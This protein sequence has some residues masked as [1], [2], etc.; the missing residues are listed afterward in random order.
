MSFHEILSGPLGQRLAWTLLHFLWQ[1]LLIGAGTAA[2]GWLLS[3]SHT[4]GRY[5]IAMI[6]LVLMACCPLVTFAILQVPA[7]PL[8]TVVSQSDLPVGKPQPPAPMQAPDDDMALPTP[9]P[10]ASR[11]VADSQPTPTPVAPP[12]EIDWRESLAR[13]ASAFQPYAVMAWLAGVVALGGRLMMSVLAV[14]RLARG[15]MPVAAE[16]AACA[17]R[18]AQRLGLS[19]SP[20]IYLSRRILEAMLVGLWRPMVLLPAAWIAEMPP[21]VL[22]AV[23]AHELAHMRRLD[24]WANLMQRLVETLLFYHPAVWW[25]SRRASLLRE[26]CADDLAVQATGDRMS[27]AGVLELLGRRRLNPPAPQLAAGIGGR[28]M[29]LFARVRNVLGAA[30]GDERLRW[31]PAG[32]L[33]LLVPLGMWLVSMGIAQTQPARLSAIVTKSTAGAEPAVPSDKATNPSGKT[34]AAN[35]ANTKPAEALTYKGT[36]VDTDGKPVKGAKIYLLYYTAAE[37]PRPPVRA[38]SGPDGTFQ[39]KMAKSEFVAR[40][41]AHDPWLLSSVVAIADGQGIGWQAGEYLEAEKQAGKRASSGTAG[42]ASSSGDKQSPDETKP[43]IRLVRDDVPIVGRIVDAKRRP[44]AGASVRILE[45]IGNR[46]NSLT[47]WLD[48]VEKRKEGYYNA[49]KYLNNGL[50]GWLRNQLQHLLPAA[51]TDQDGRFR[52]TGVG[53]ERIAHL[54][55]EGPGIA[56]EQLDVRTRPGPTLHVKNYAGEAAPPA[57]TYY[58]AE[59]EHIAAPSQQIAGTVRDKNTHLPLVGVTIL[60]GRYNEVYG[61]SGGNFIRAKT[62]AQGHYRLRGL[63]SG[64]GNKLL[65]IPPLDGPH[66][67]SLKGID[68]QA[69]Q[70]GNVDF[71]LTHGILIRGRVT[72]VA[73]G[74]PVSAQ[75]DYFVF[76]DNPHARSAP[77]FRGFDYGHFGNFYQT[78]AKG[79]Y[80]IPGLPGRGIVTASPHDWQSYLRGVGAE[81]I[82]GGDSRAGLLKFT[83]EPTWCFPNNSGALVEI[84]PDENATKVEVNFALQPQK[85]LSVMLLDPENKPLRSAIYNEGNELGGWWPRDSEIFRITDYRPARPQTLLFVH[86]QRKLAG[87]LLLKGPQQGQLALQ[88]Q[89]WGVVSGC[90]VDAHGKPQA[91]VFVMGEPFPFAKVYKFPP[92]KPF[93]RAS[94]GFYVK[95][96]EGGRFTV[97]GLAPGVAY[98]IDVANMPIVGEE[99]RKYQGTKPWIGRIA[100]GVVVQSGET[101]DLGNVTPKLKDLSAFLDREKKAPAAP[102]AKESPATGSAAKPANEKQPAK[103]ANESPPASGPSATADRA[104]TEAT[105]APARGLAADPNTDQAKAIAAIETLSGK[106]TVDEN[107][108]V[109]SVDF[110]HGWLPWV[111]NNMPAVRLDPVRVPDAGLANLEGLRQLQSLNLK[112]TEV[113]DAGIEHL[114]GLTKLQSL[115]LEGTLVTDAGLEH[116]QGLAQLQSLSLEGTRITDAGLEHLKGLSQL[117]SLSLCITKTDVELA[118]R[119]GMSPL[120]LQNVL[121]TQMEIAD[122]GLVHLEGLTQLQSLDLS[123]TKVAGAGLAHLKGLTKFRRLGLRNTNVN[124][125]GLANL[126]GLSKLESLDLESTRVTDAGLRHLEGLLQLNFLSL[127][128]TKVTDAGLVHLKRLPELRTLNLVLTNVT[129]AGLIHLKELPKLRRLLLS[130]T[131]VTDLGLVHLEGLPQLRSLFLT[132]TEVTDAGLAN[133]EGMP[134]LLALYLGETKVTDAGLDH[135]KGLTQIQ[136]LEL[137]QTKVTDAGLEKLRG[138]RQLSILRLKRTKVT[139]AG[140]KKLQQTLPNCKID[141]TPAEEHAAPATTEPAVPKGNDPSG[142]PSDAKPADSASPVEEKLRKEWADR[143]LSV[144]RDF[145]L[146]PAYRKLEM[147]DVRKHFRITAAQERKLWEIAAE[148]HAVTK[149][150]SAAHDDWLR[151]PPPQRKTTKEEG[152]ARLDQAHHA[153]DKPVADVLT[154]EQRAAYQ[155][156]IRGDEAFNVIIPDDRQYTQRIFGF[157]LSDEQRQQLTRLREEVEE[158]RKRTRTNMEEQAL[159][160]L[161]TQQREKLLARFSDAKPFRPSALVPGSTQQR[162]SLATK[163]SLDFQFVSGSNALVRVYP[164]LTDPNVRKALALTAEQEAKLLAIQTIS[165]AKAIKLFERYESKAPA[166]ESPEARNARHAEYRRKKDEYQRTLKQFAQEVIG[167]IMAVLQPRQVAALKAMAQKD[168]AIGALEGLDRAA[169]DDIH[170]TVEQR[171]KLR[172]IT[173]EYEAHEYPVPNMPLPSAAG[174]KAWAILTPQQKKKV[175]ETIERWGW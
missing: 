158:N 44:V 116:L 68:K 23:I 60:N 112:N 136:Q 47:D 161:T 149:K 27:Y 5:A 67:I 82:K 168:K 63:P 21:D 17:N 57:W 162:P 155:H 38:V 26:M 46:N 127:W 71:D 137:D 143:G 151:L 31:W 117:E 40:G 29:A 174:E 66:L 126:K 79:N 48:A 129:D 73:T 11:V 130:G 75:I 142:K 18:L 88:L 19:A 106:V 105:L 100:T 121:N 97:N 34:A 119:Q 169:L 14:R 62:D 15:R 25:L 124:D 85:E 132:R 51:T 141:Y 94:V 153:F 157:E 22:E 80:S 147:P 125:A 6:G 93:E 12:I 140:M 24:L 118:L 108:Q 16:L 61:P 76:S 111:P 150:L 10:L 166:D 43:V 45:I 164:E 134:Q 131:K 56:T 89:P 9:P 175:D 59:F 3:P 84:D 70:S 86:L 110:A 54:L 104:K 95:T 96:D 65:A 1:G 172:Q 83:T 33:A 107:K 36:V 20:G 37:L 13:R 41:E 72:D 167:Q 139:E 154:A 135:L 90:V 53:R 87:S 113:T 145:M 50:T 35:T 30:P 144:P 133:L 102:K 92:Q 99:G 163:P 8:V 152:Y 128:G 101:K 165:Q 42:A 74:K 4:R 146:L 123:C 170:A 2:A 58:G 98:D 32:L 49:S 115:N 171:A 120:E 78:D 77:G 156:D 69:T 138:L 114:K 52:L 91:D 148:Y 109:K 55:L 81:K 7:P 122:A 64:E 28:R 39:F 160:V 173:E 159:A 103:P